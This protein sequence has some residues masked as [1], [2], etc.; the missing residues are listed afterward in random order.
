M[1]ADIQTDIFS[2]IFMSQQQHCLQPRPLYRACEKE[3][4]N[5]LTD[6]CKESGKMDKEEMQTFAPVMLNHLSLL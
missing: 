1:I 5:L 4:R 6:A 3:L 2:D